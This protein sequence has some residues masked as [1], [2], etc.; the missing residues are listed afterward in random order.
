MR[1][2][3]ASNNAT[4]TVETGS[5]AVLVAA[6][7]SG[8]SASTRPH[9]PS[10]VREMPLVDG[11]P[12]DSNLV[13][14]VGYRGTNF[15]GYAEQ[16]GE[17]SVA[18]ELRRA[19]ET[20]LRRPCE[21]VCAGRTDAGVS[22]LGQCVSIPVMEDELQSR[23]SERLS[24]ALMALTPDDISIRGVYR[25]PAMF[26]ARFDALGRMYCYRIACGNARP[27]MAWDHA[28]WYRGSLDIAA[29]DDAA[30]LFVGE[31]DF[32][33]FCKATSAK[34]LDEN[35]RSTSRYVE[36]VQVSA[37]EEAGE[38]LVFVRV[39]GNAFLHNM[40]RIMV[41]SLVEVGRGHRDTAWLERTMEARD[42]AA[43]GP[44][45]P[46]KGLVLQGVTYPAGMLQPL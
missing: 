13:L 33:S 22:A 15:A 16:P 9:G 2:K 36:S 3:T 43:A 41:G 38:S 45:A 7:P 32:R 21:L 28:W 30:Q 35:G 27:V 31:H 17:R 12:A 40:V 8:I 19:V 46:A 34:L 23:S 39:S 20:V 5:A 24:R 25:A 44:T 18:G 11:D 1:S 14:K 37:G 10:P 26:S 29:M 4:T 42:R 6:S